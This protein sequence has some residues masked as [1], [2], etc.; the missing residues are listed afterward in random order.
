MRGKIVGAGIHLLW[1]T[2]DILWRCPLRASVVDYVF[3]L[4]D[5]IVGACI[6]GAFIL[7]I[8]SMYCGCIL[9]VH[10]VHLIYCGCNVLWTTCTHNTC[11]C[12]PQYI[13][14]VGT[15]C[16]CNQGLP[17]C[18]S[19]TMQINTHTYQ[20]TAKKNA[21]R[22]EKAPCAHACPRTICRF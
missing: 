2:F 20:N 1:V 21:Q 6:V 10:I 5:A 9:W 4:V 7:W 16:G 3:D 22:R 11:G 8:T 18:T 14:I 12:H 19:K 15:Y 13:C 17:M